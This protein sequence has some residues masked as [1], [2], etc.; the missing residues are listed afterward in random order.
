MNYQTIQPGFIEINGANSSL[1]DFNVDEIKKFKAVIIKNLREI[2]EK[3]FVD[4]GAKFGPI[5]PYENGP[6]YSFTGEAQDEI[7]LHYDGISASN[8]KKIPNW[9][10]FYVRKASPIENGGAF[11]VADAEI[12]LK[13]VSDE[14]KEFLRSTRLQFFGY[15]AEQ[16]KNKKFDEFSFEIKPIEKFSDHES[17]RVF[18]PS[19]E[20]RFV[21]DS[22]K[23]FQGR[24]REESLAIFNDLKNALYNPEVIHRFSF[25]DHDVLI[26]NNKLTFHG[27]ERFNQPV[28]RTLDRIQALSADAQE[29]ALKI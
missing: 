6:I 2:P 4:F 23:I 12:A 5:L 10:I 27:R 21:G 17:L 8:P 13:F 11:K 15:F 1:K 7:E 28:L 26:L 9:L 25:S 24:T 16:M 22:K 14:I 18:L 3:D 29:F 20:D 19:L